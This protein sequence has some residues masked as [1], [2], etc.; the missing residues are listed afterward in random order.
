M[1]TRIP[2]CTKPDTYELAV[3]IQGSRIAGLVK[4]ALANF[5]RAPRGTL[6]PI[7]RMQSH[8]T[9]VDTIIILN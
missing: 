4:D 6:A 3:A 2:K 7:I 5:R 8:N 1:V 9:K